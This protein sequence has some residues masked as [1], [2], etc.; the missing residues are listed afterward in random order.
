MTAMLCAGD[1]T[2]DGLVELLRSVARDDESVPL[3]CW[4]EAPDGWAFDWWPGTGGDLRWCK[5]AR[6]PHKIT[7][8]EALQRSTSGR[9]FAPDGELRWRVIPSRDSPICRIVFLGKAPWVGDALEDHSDQLAELT[10][11]CHA[12]I[13][14]GQQTESSPGEWIELRIPQRFRYPVEGNPQR[15]KLLTEYWVDSLGEPHF[16][17]LCDLQ[18]F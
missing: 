18:P 16:I 12:H 14:W 5:A 17:R 8:A 4:V 2:R 13:M 11:K 3:R 1:H 7:V 15:V 6:N 10:S 9:L